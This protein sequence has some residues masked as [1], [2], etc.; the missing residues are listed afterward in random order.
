MCGGSRNCVARAV[1]VILRL[2]TAC[3]TSTE[4]KVYYK[5]LT[6]GDTE[7]IFVYWKNF[8]ILEKLGLFLKSEMST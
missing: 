4:E 5:K 7:K 3:R 2:E 6:N 1:I 8:R